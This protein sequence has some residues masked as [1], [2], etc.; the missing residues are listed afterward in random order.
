LASRNR[1]ILKEFYW[2]VCRASLFAS[3]AVWFVTVA[4]GVETHKVLMELNN[5]HEYWVEAAITLMAL[6]GIL[7]L[8]WGDIS[9]YIKKETEEG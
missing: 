1:M 3:Y 7:Y 5:Y 4:A 2:F 6:P 8:L 9:G